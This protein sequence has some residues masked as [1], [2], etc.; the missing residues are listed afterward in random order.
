MQ[1]DKIGVSFLKVMALCFFLVVNVHLII[2]STGEEPFIA[3]RP[4]DAWQM[5]ILTSYCS[6]LWMIF[7]TALVRKLIRKRE[8]WIKLFLNIVLIIF[9]ISMI[10]TLYLVQSYYISDLDKWR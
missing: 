7:T 1:F 5:L 6:C 4:K 10:Y 3:F 8:N 9:C 2:Y